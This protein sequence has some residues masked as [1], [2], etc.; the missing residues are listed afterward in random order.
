MNTSNNISVNFG[1]NIES[2]YWSYL[3]EYWGGASSGYPD[4]IYEPAITKGALTFDTTG[5]NAA[6]TIG[7]SSFYRYGNLV[8]GK[9]VITTTSK[10]LETGSGA[11]VGILPL[12]P[13]STWQFVGAITKVAFYESACGYVSTS[14]QVFIYMGKE[15]E[16]YIFNIQFPIA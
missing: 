9:M 7:S 6:L 12:V 2:G 10:F 11:L 16:T 14:G 15:N 1:G 8:I 3:F 5:K 4:P 13:T